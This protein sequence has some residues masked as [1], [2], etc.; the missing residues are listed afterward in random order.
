MPAKKLPMGWYKFLVNFLL[1]IYAVINA[2]SAFSY[3]GGMGH[4]AEIYETFPSLYMLDMGYGVLTLGVAVLAV[5]TRFALTGYKRSAP[6]LSVGFYLY[7]FAI[8][9]VYNILLLSMTGEGYEAVDYILTGMSVGVS[10]LISLTFALCNFVYF[11]K[12]KHMFN[13]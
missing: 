2:V 13:K 11:K 10:A 12:R 8:S 6:A 3:I 5:M 9:L 7:G 4:T 1:W